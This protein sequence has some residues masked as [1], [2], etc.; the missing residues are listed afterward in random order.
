MTETKTQS[1]FNFLSIFER[2]IDELSVQTEDAEMLEL[3]RRRVV[4]KVLQEIKKSAAA[5]QQQPILKG[6]WNGL[7]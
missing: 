6:V 5:Q 3:L 1:A 2:E 4:D 7:D